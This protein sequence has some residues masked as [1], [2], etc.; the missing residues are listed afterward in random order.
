MR[1]GIVYAGTYRRS[2]PL[3]SPMPDH[4]SAGSFCLDCSSIRRAII[5][6]N[7]GQAKLRGYLSDNTA[8]FS[9][10]IVGRDDQQSSRLI[11]GHS[12]PNQM[13]N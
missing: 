7:N 13:L 8:H 1:Q 5:Y 6:Y 10:F 9:L 3:I 12:S 4:E 11:L 2:Y